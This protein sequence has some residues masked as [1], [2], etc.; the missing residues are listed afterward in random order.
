E[1]L[2]CAHSGSH[3]IH[4]HTGGIGRHR[5]DAS[6]VPILGL[7]LQRS[8]ARHELS[9]QSQSV[10]HPLGRVHSLVRRLPIDVQDSGEGQDQI[11]IL[12]QPHTS[13][14]HSTFSNGT[15]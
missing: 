12:V 13:S 15:I 6:G 14:S 5:E 1:L 9:A 8:P 2:Y 11:G 7:K 3:A 4:V 10:A